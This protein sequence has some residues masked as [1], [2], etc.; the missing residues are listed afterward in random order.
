VAAFPP[1]DASALAWVALAPLFVAARRSPP[2]RAA[3]AGLLAGFVFQTGYGWWVVPAGLHPGAYLLGCAFAALFPGGFAAAAAWQHRRAPAWSG[4]AFPALWVLA[5]YARGHVGFGSSPWGMLGYTQLGVTPVARIA[6]AA[7]VLGV[8]FALAAVNGA[9]AWAVD[10]RSWRAPG[11]LG[12]ALALTAALAL[13]W[14]GVRREPATP[15]RTLRVAIVQAGRGDDVVPDSEAAARLLEREGQLTRSA[16]AGGAALVVWPESSVPAPL[17]KDREALGNLARLARELQIHLLVSATR[18]DSAVEGETGARANSA[19]LFGPSGRLEGRYDKLRLLPF[20]EYVPARGWV[21][22]PQW[23]APPMNDAAPGDAQTVFGVDGARFAVQLCWENFFPG[24]LRSVA[25][26]P[27]DFAVSMT[28][29]AF[30]SAAAG[31]RQLYQIN[32]MRAVESGAP[33]VRAAT[34]GVSAILGPDGRELARVRGGD[35]SD[36]DAIGFALADV[37]LQNPP[38]PYARAGDWL[39]AAAALVSGAAAVAALRRRRGGAR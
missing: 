28:N 34:T 24:T 6:A 3:A 14:V 7:G 11:G 38:S 20:V 8:S 37:P 13:S 27:L 10:G 16:A 23:I 29:E 1:H 32:A 15:P 19:F 39:V 9:L 4:L 36:L 26:D 12:A 25:P 22:W 17:P 30:A 18:H 35:G 21:A 31:R 2:L 33:L 5:E